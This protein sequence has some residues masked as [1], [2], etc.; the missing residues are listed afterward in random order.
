[1]FRHVCP[2]GSS[3]RCET[4]FSNS[5]FFFVV[6]AMQRVKVSC[7]LDNYF[8]FML[9]LCRV[10]T[11]RFGPHVD[12]CRLNM[13]RMVSLCPFL[14]HLIVFLF[15]HPVLTVK[16]GHGNSFSLQSLHYL[17]FFPYHCGL[18]MHFKGS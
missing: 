10:H 9:L 1:M 7:L 17:Y 16:E 8:L 18:S 14:R 13:K 3:E 5:Y 4:P 12:I 11:R 2:P 6:A 15:S